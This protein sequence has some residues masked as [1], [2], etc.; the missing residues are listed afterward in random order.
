MEPIWP[1]HNVQLS[2]RPHGIK[3][4]MV[5]NS[6]EMDRSKF[7]SGEVFVGNGPRKKNTIYRRRRKVKPFFWNSKIREKKWNTTHGWR[8]PW[9]T[10]CL[11]L[12]AYY[13]QED[14]ILEALQDEA[15]EKMRQARQRLLTHVLTEYGDASN[16]A[17]VDVAV[18]SSRTDRQKP[19]SCIQSL[20]AFKCLEASHKNQYW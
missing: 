2:L 20:N 7:Y 5:F 16:G 3:H 15:K 12:P 10:P 19:S 9:C 1:L 18:F 13:K 17:V 8:N 4:S 11:S 6:K 14:T